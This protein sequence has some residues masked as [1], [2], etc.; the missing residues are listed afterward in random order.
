MAVLLASVAMSVVLC[1]VSH[2]SSLV[3]PRAV[4]RW[5]AGATV[6]FAGF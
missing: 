2:G 3:S 5:W 1:D 4:K 6:F